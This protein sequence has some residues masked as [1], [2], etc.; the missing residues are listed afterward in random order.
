MLTLSSKLVPLENKIRELE[1]QSHD[2]AAIVTA[3]H[4]SQAVIEFDLT[5]KI[6]A[7]NENFLNA[8]G[9]GA[10]EVIGNRHMMFC[11]ENY[12]SSQAYRQFWDNLGRGEPQTGE[13]KRFGKGGKEIW[14]NASYNP[15]LDLNGKVV[16]VI[17]TATDITAAKLE[18]MNASRLKLALDTCTANVMM[19]DAQ[20]NIIY[21]NTALAEFLNEAESD[22]KKDLPRFDVKNLI[23]VN[24]DVF[25]KNPA[26]QR[27][28]LE[29]LDSTYQ[30]SIQVGGRSFNLVANPIYGVNHERLGTVV[31]WQDGT[32]LG[33]TQALDKS[34]AIIEFMPDGTIV[35]ANENF[36][37]A[38]GYGATEIV[39]RKHAMFCDPAYTAS[40]EYKQFW[41]ALGR[42]EA[43]TGEFKRFGKGGKEIW[44]N[45]SY[46]P[47]LDLRGKVVRV[48]KTASDVTEMVMARTENEMGMN[49]AVDVLTG[50]SQ[51]DLTKKMTL[52]YKGTFGQIKTA[53][54]STVD[55]LY[56][57]VKT[58]IESAQSVNSAASEI[59]SGSTDLSQRTEEQASSLEETA[60]SMEE[61]TGTVKQNSSNAAIANDLSSKA[62]QVA[63][64][65]G[66]VVEQAVTAMGSIEESS[67]KI[68]DIISVIDEI[69][70]QTNLLALNAAVEAARAGDAGKGFAVV[71]SEVRSLAGRSASA[72]KE[73]KALINESAQQVQNGAKLVNQA[74]G[75]LK[76]IVE[77]VKQVS[78]IVSEIASASQEQATGIDEIN[79]AITQMDEVTQQN[80]ALVEENTAA[81]TSMVEQARDLENLM[82][83]FKIDDEAGISGEFDEADILSLEHSQK[84]NAKA[85][86]KSKT[87]PAKSVKKISDRKPAKK[88]AAAGLKVVQDDDWKEF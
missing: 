67:K 34:Q 49:E 82:S 17:K 4:K 55:Q 3:I 36:L 21:M 45:A 64:D 53:V 48:V 24:I 78:S 26:A 40:P 30:T 14:I 79:T 86:S 62:N 73:I 51:G 72:S 81:A 63:N 18:S 74:G 68:S 47:I 69:A 57:M 15:I 85:L 1:S 29:K 16:R 44:I 6:L 23:G 41:E 66:R 56:E 5:G 37:G 54:N 32:A 65:G 59:S 61:I 22:I 20:Y 19:A 9:Y 60:A 80:A 50:I 70:F 28:M 38:M 35:K 71:A 58:I 52:D 75:T 7:A 87:A 31:E 77:S 33:L 13:F 83:F 25:H 76:D 39:G 42:G 46:N 84:R 8:M 88:A 2:C 27:G 11:D 10:H 43:Q 12:T